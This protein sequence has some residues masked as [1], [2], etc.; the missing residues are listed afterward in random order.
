MIGVNNECDIG[1]VIIDLKTIMDRKK[2]TVYRLSK[3][4]GIKY[5]NIKKYYKNQ[6]YRIDLYNLAKI[7]Y[8]L[9]CE[10]YEI[11]KYEKNDN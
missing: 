9:E 8:V 2:I 4:T 5:D 11:I 10:P 6:L 3:L 1:K 7:C